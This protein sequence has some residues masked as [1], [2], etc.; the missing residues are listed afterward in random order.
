LAETSSSVA[1][2][3]D[4]VCANAAKHTRNKIHRMKN[5]VTRVK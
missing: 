4:G 2:V 1:D 3:A 5:I